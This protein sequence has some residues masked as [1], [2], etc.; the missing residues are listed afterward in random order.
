[1]I[2]VDI[3]TLYDR[4]KDKW[5]TRGGLFLFLIVLIPTYYILFKYFNIEG[6]NDYL[7]LFYLLIPISI[8]FITVFIWFCSTNRLFLRTSNKITAGIIIIIDSEKDRIVISKIVRKV[9]HQIN[10]S[11]S[12]SNVCIKILPA[13]SFTSDKEVEKYHNNF[14]FMYDV[15]IRLFIEAG[16][17][18]S[19]EKII[20]EKLSVTFRPKD[21]TPQKRVFF[22]I[23]DLARD[24]ELQVRSRDWEYLLTNSGVDNKK[25]FENI[26]PIFLYYIGF[27]AIYVDRF[28][29]ALEIMTPIYNSKNT[30]IPITKKEG[31]QII[32]TLKPLNLAEA[33]LAAILVDLFFYTA[34]ISYH[35][36]ET[37]KALRYF[38]KLE[39]IIKTH[40]NKFDQYI[41]M[42]RYS[43][44]L[45]NLDDAIRYTDLAKKIEPNSVAVF[46]NLGFFAILND[47]KKAFCQNYFEIYKNRFRSNL[48][49]V[50][51]LD[52]Q[53]K[54]KEKLNN[55][56]SYFE[57]T[58]SFIEYV[59]LDQINIDS[60][61]K[62][63][64]NYKIEVDFNCIYKL[65]LEILTSGNRLQPTAIK[66]T[67]TIR[68]KKKRR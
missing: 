14:N 26:L 27:Y 19:I 28:E 8:I 57:F 2:K 42:A 47:D 22:N 16:Q 3:I 55:R 23:V 33:R 64:E 51:I 15:I 52:F 29:D 9:I 30:I 66:K 10:N 31:N 25:Y 13:N 56:D 18:S 65:G 50:D 39:Q 41:N 63:V 48:N 46:L 61:R 4:L 44:E 59:F 53:L 1:M 60:F 7:W 37:E 54:Q 58:T 5:E 17:Y 40:P 12:F 68:K 6:L 24:M 62:I 21:Q 43:Y 32:L 38:E 34:V 20:V 35:K 45:E 67:N 11:K 49:W 36:S